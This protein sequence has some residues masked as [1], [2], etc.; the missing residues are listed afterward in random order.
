MINWRKSSESSFSPIPDD[1]RFEIKFAAS[2]DEYHR[3]L[4]WVSL[5]PAAFRAPYPSRWIHSAYFDTID[6][7]AYFANIAGVSARSKV[8]YRWYGDSDSPQKGTLEVKKKRGQYGW[9]LFYPVPEKRWSDLSRWRTVIRHIRAQ[10]PPDGRFYLD[11]APRPMLVNR[12]LRKYFV[13]LDNTVRLT[14]DR[15]Q[16]VFDQRFSP[17]PN[18]LRGISYATHAVVE[19]KCSR[20]DRNLAAAAIQSIPL[21]ACKNSKYVQALQAVGHV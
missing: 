8:R 2:A 4:H 18:T 12:Y 6:Y 9:K 1:A 7:E 13:T 14:V 19:V 17:S 3:L 15:H 10:L 21:R 16:S 11:A 20:S 5:H